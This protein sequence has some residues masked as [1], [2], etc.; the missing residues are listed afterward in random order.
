MRA[1]INDLPYILVA[2]CENI[3]PLKIVPSKRGDSGP[4]EATA[5]DAQK[6]RKIGDSERRPKEA[7]ASECVSVTEPAEAVVSLAAVVRSLVRGGA[8]GLV[9]DHNVGGTICSAFS[10]KREQSTNNKHLFFGAASAVVPSHLT[11]SYLRYQK[12]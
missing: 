8:G 4:K 7:T 2:P 10:Q 12:Y 9:E 11:F 1:L 5:S 6:R 3:S